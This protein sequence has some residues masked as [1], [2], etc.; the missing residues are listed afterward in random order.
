MTERARSA[1]AVIGAGVIGLSIAHDLA[2]AGHRVSVLAEHDAAAVTS[3]AAAAL[4]FPHAVEQS[5]RI[6]ASAGHTLQRLVALADR[7]G[8]GV[9]MRTGTVLYRRPDPDLT[10]TAA[11]PRWCRVAEADLPAG[12]SGV[13]CELPVVVTDVYLAWLRT[14]VVELGVSIVR[15]TVSSID[16]AL[17]EVQ[18]CDC[19]VVAAGIRSAALLGDDERVYPIRGQIVR[20]ANPGLSR[21]LLDDENPAGLTYIVPRDHDVV[22]GGTGEAGSWD[23]TIHPDIEASILSRAEALE[24]ALRGQPVLSRAVGLRPGRPTVRL[25]PVPGHPVPVYAA[26]GHGGS[27]YTLS[28]GDAATIAALVEGLR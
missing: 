20:V 5:D 18:P 27:G 12:A 13:Q 24:P 22:C 17:R 8:T 9:R 21:W 1:V 7:P 14:A 4:W 11:V 15:R 3:G 2:V 23:Q 10:W 25:G 19:I 28:W 26:Y 6:L 16:G